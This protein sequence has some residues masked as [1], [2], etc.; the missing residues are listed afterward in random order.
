M[1]KSGPESGDEL[2]AKQT[3]EYLNGEKEARARSNP[4]G[5]I[6][7]ESAGGDD[8]VDMGMKLEFL[9]PGVQ[10]AEEANLGPRD[11]WDYE[12]LA[13]AFLRWREAANHR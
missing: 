13:V 5:V 1:L 9:I 12:P 11:A 7:R 8:T 3:P 6:E 4:A 10:H 2:A